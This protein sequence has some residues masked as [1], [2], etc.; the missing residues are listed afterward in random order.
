MGFDFDN[1]KQRT[2]AKIILKRCRNKPYPN[3]LQLTNLVIAKSDYK[4]GESVSQFVKNFV[5]SGETP[6]E[7]KDNKVCRKDIS[8][9]VVN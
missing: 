3:K 2:A 4:S 5:E 1:E 8:F 6:L 7:S 9:E